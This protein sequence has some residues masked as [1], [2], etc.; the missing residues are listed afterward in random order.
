MVKEKKDEIVE[1]ILAVMRIAMSLV[2]GIR[3]VLRQPKVVKKAGARSALWL[4][5]MEYR[6]R[7]IRVA[8]AERTQDR[9]GS[10]QERTFLFCG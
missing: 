2:C 1:K 4:Y 3:S 8:S 9:P 10:D 5:I 7:G 6:R